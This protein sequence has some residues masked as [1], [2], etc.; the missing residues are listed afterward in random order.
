MMTTHNTLQDKRGT[1]TSHLNHNRSG[2]ALAHPRVAQATPSY[3]D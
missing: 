1:W 3:S 2:A